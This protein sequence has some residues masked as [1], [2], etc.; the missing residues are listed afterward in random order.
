MQCWKDILKSD[1]YLTSVSERSCNAPSSLYSGF[2]PNLLYADKAE[3]PHS[4]LTLV[5]HHIIYL[6]PLPPPQKIYLTL[7]MRERGSGKKIKLKHLFYTLTV[8]VKCQE[9]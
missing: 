4:K 2:W 3:I 6:R 5:Y 9:Q 1:V 7:P 8:T